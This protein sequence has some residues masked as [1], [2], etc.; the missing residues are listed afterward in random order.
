MQSRA[1]Q[2]GYTC[3]LHGV[4][5]AAGAGELG[6]EIEQVGAGPGQSEQRVALEESLTVSEGMELAGPREPVQA[7]S[8]ARLG[9]GS[10]T[11]PGEVEK[12]PGARVAGAESREGAKK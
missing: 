2:I 10:G 4:L 9:P 5:E 3:E 6:S 8:T 1:K 11:R 7:E 12:Q